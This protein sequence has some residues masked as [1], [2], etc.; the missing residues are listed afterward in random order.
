L[1]TCRNGPVSSNVSR[2]QI[3]LQRQSFATYRTCS[4][5]TLKSPALAQPRKEV[6]AAVIQASAAPEADTTLREKSVHQSRPW[7]AKA[8]AST[9]ACCAKSGKAQKN[10]KHPLRQALQAAPQHRRARSGK[11]DAHTPGSRA[12]STIGSSIVARGCR[13][14][15][16]STGPIAAG[17]QSPAIS[18][19]GFA[20]L[21]Q[22]AG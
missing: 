18:F 3:Q 12:K 15:I 16:R 9:C 14:T 19:W 1:P 11:K 2:H 10:Q 4:L 7:A 8:T 17:G 21:P 5:K 13:L 20:H 6:D 22:R